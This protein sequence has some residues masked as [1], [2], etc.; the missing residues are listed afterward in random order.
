MSDFIL[1]P[2]SLIRVNRD[3]RQ[4]REILEDEEFDYLCSSIQ[5]H[6]ILAPLIVEHTPQVLD[7]EGRGTY[8]LI[9]GERRY[10][11][12]KRLN[13]TEVPVL[14]KSNISSD[15]SFLIELE[16]NI[17]RQD[18]PWQDRV[19]AIT[20]FHE[21]HQRNDPN[22][23][24]TKTGECLRLTAGM[25]NR[26]LS[27]GAHAESSPDVFKAS[28]LSNAY[29]QSVRAADRRISLELDKVSEGIGAI[30][31]PPSTTPP[32][33]D[34][35]RPAASDILCLNSI[36]W[37]KTYEGERFNLIHC[38]FPYGISVHDSGF[39]VERHGDRQN[40]AYTDTE[41]TYKELLAAF[42]ENHSRFM[43]SQTHVIFW[44]SMAF[45]QTTVEA[46]SK[47]L[48]VCPHPFIWHK[49]DNKGIISDAQRRPRHIYETALL[50][51][52]G[53]RKIVRNISDTISAPTAKGYHMSIKPIP[54]LKYLLSMYLDE[55][56]SLLDPTSGSGT[57][58]R[59]ADDLGAKRVLGLELRQHFVDE[60]RH[61]LHHDRVKR[62][63]HK[64]FSSE[65]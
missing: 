35:L 2:L 23:T 64:K 1:I 57:A 34:T 62:A 59:A 7:S 61:D 10:T 49:S 39:L 38:D 55:D 11:A 16:E 22:W 4:R 26:Y 43:A 40:L 17:A 50:C 58:I 44:F 15:D 24:R 27:V 19:V 56:T 8:L 14:L 33:S 36:D 53:D 60:S 52:R 5:H 31:A 63:L 37:M 30:V 41:A 12:A 54:V 29:S 9:A 47:F 28:T 13:F 46:L 6:G 18:L 48:W 21:Q 65:K 25:I 3:T 45:Y 42:C 51:S 32:S 20:A